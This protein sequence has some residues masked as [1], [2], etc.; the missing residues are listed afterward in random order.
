MKDRPEASYRLGSGT[1][2]VPDLVFFGGEP[3]YNNVAW[4][5]DRPSNGFLKLPG[6]SGALWPD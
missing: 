2:M 6:A 5:L 3:D 1:A 4:L